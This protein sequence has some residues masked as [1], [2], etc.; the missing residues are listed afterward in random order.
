M[1]RKSMDLKD[2][3]TETKELYIIKEKRETRVE[4]FIP[5][6]SYS[7]EGVGKNEEAQMMIDS[8]EEFIKANE[9][10]VLAKYTAGD[11]EAVQEGFKRA[12]AITGLYF[13]SMYLD[14]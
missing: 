8:L 12:I 4:D 9:D 13:K 2:E 7:Y 1:N 11:I 5:D 3:T 6:Y 14:G 10:V